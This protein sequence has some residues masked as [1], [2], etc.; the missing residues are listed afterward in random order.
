MKRMRLAFFLLNAIVLT[1]ILL[2][3]GL[4]SGTTVVAATT[5]LYGLD[6]PG[7]GAVRRMLY[8]HN[9][10]PIYDATYVFKV[11]PRK[12]TTGPTGYYT[13]FFWGNDGR[14]DWQSGSANTYYGA[15]PYPIPAPGGPGQWEISV[16]SNDYVTGSE[17]QWDRWY[18]QA[19]RAW[20]E[21]S[22]ITHHEFYWDWPDT[23]KVISRTVVD[24]N[25]AK[26]NPPTPAI[27]V[28]Q[29]PNFNGASWGGYPGWEEFNGIIRGIQIYSGLLSMADLQ[30]EIN[31]PQSTTAGQN[32]IWYLN[33]D[34]RPGDVTDKK[35]I[36]TPHNPSWAG[37]TALEWTDQTSSD[38]TP[39]SAPTNLTATVVSSSQIN[40]SWAGST[41]NVGVT[42]YSIERCPGSACT[43]FS[44]ISTAA[45]TS[46]LDNGLAANTSYRYRVRAT[47]A[48]GNL[49]TYSSIASA[50][51]LA[52]PDSTPPT[53]SVS[54]PANG[55]T[56]SGTTTV[57]ATASDNVGVAG[58]QF[59]LDGANL[60]AEDTTSPYSV[61]WNTTTTSN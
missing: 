9:P 32:L 45:G 61:S 48:A 38:T 18:T 10:F 40:L 29:A 3:M 13:T 51:T 42:G 50:T 23:S 56:V 41:D 28:G 2:A 44:Q 5:P 60:G 31:A 37:T 6:W 26:Q 21:S 19:F 1:L 59:K 39:P 20:R 4:N 14:F 36:G 25:W 8:W 22:S 34:P 53:V 49:S 46:H 35:T 30:A 16:N 11:F 57:S 24:S 52:P 55:A 17:V 43:N 58:V 15:H 47:D 12:K 7:N 54:A 27:V 33:T